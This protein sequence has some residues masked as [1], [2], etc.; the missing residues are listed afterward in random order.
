MHEKRAKNAEKIARKL[1]DMADELDESVTPENRQRMLAN[2]K[3]ATELL[4]TISPYEV[5]LNNTPV[6]D[7]PAGQVGNKPA[8]PG[9]VSSGG[10]GGTAVGGNVAPNRN[11]TSGTYVGSADAQTARFLARKFWSIAIEARKQSGALIEEE[12]SDAR[13]HRQEKEFFEKTA[14]YER[15]EE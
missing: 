1:L 7:G 15:D 13:Y 9:S 10:L 8:N 4:N 2:L 12:A 14:A 5:T 3:A 11:V 6:Q